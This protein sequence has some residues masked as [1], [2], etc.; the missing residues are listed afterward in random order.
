MYLYSLSAQACRWG[1]WNGKSKSTKGSRP[2]AHGLA[3]SVYFTQSPGGAVEHVSD[4][5]HKKEY[6]SKQFN[7]SNTV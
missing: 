1:N 4:E 3:L 6:T 5:P 2:A 7:T